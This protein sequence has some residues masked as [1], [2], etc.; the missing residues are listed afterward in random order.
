MLLHHAHSIS[1]GNTTPPPPFN[2]PHLRSQNPPWLGAN[3]KGGQLCEPRQ[4]QRPF[5][6]S[7]RPLEPEGPIMRGGQINVGGNEGWGAGIPNKKKS[8]LVG[9]SPLNSQASN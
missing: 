3:Y 5:L 9:V 7:M 6:G 2:W 4:G 8:N 1:G